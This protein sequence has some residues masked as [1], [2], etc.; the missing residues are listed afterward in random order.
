M[1]VAG[2]SIK[3]VYPIKVLRVVDGDTFYADIDLGFQ[4]WC[5][6]QSIRLYGVDAYESLGRNAS[7]KGQQAK[8]FTELWLSAA[9]S[10]TLWSRKYN[11]REKYGRIMGEVFSEGNPFSLNQALIDNGHALPYT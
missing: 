5:R 4:F 8:L 3:W 11:D 7:E 10:P 9:V 1:L 2:V 6:N